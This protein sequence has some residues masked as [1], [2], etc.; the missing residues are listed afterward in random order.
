MIIKGGLLY[1]D[2]GLIR[3]DISI[4]DDG[5]I[6][7]I[8]KDL[9]GKDA[10]DASGLLV[11]PGLVNTHT[12]TA[13]TLL[14][15]VGDDMPLQEWLADKIWP[16]EANLTYDDCY[17]GN[18]FGMVEMI[19]TGT[20]CLN[21][22]Y[23]FMDSLVEALKKTG[24]RGSICHGIIDLFDEEKAKRELK[25]S[26]RIHEL[27]K[28]E[29]LITFCMG[30][31]SPYTCSK[32]LLLSVKEYA[33]END[34]KVHIHTSETRKEY[35]DSI[36]AHKMSPIAYLDSLSMLDSNSL[37]AHCVH[38]SDDD[39]GILSRTGANVL[40][41]PC[42]NLKLSSGT[43]RV[44]SMLDRSI[45]VA[46]ATDGASSNNSLDMQS[47]MKTMALIHKSGSPTNLPA[48]KA[49]QIA[50]LNGARA[51]DANC[52]EIAKGRC[53]D[54]MFVDPKHFS[55]RPGHNPMSNVVYS[56]RPEAI[57]HV[58]VN[59]QMLMEDR[60]ILVLDEDKVLEKADQHAE[61]LVDRYNENTDNQ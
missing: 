10:I 27:C 13:M 55:M 17:W 2:H 22:M 36:S 20:T 9:D 53:A 60:N 30:P 18:L 32:E 29:D 44:P 47:E 51:L 4:G 34:I 25:E 33:N 15:G 50:T 41:C 6:D 11:L 12:H 5:T 37:L 16:L 52:G 23:F 54:L 21:D 57:R 58:M 35:D 8:S 59:G 61:K 56:M 3:A 48:D 42:S 38:L 46:L 43:A 49:F 39:I 1:Y 40:H 31:H 14:R 45:N 28:G 24:M 19:K 26:L 7:D